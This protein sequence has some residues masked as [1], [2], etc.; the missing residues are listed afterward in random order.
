[1]KCVFVHWEPMRREDSGS[2]CRWLGPERIGK[3]SEGRLEDQETHM[4][5][6]PVKLAHCRSSV[7]PFLVQNRKMKGRL[8]APGLVPHLH[9]P[10]ALVFGSDPFL[11]QFRQREEDVHEP[12]FNL[13]NKARR[14]KATFKDSTWTVITKEA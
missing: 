1:M 6:S 4:V 13:Q 7:L 9:N 14:K 11:R 10:L 5:Y 2:E 12:V 8:V 3:K